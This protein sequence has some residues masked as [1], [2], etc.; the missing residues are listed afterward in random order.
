[1]ENLKFISKTKTVT[2]HFSKLLI[3][4]LLT[5]TFSFQSCTKKKKETVKESRDFVHHSI[6]QKVRLGDGIPLSIDVSVRWKVEDFASF[7]KQ[8]SN[9]NEFDSL[10]LTPRKLEL[11][12]II[13][14]QFD[15]VDTLFNSKRQTYIKAMKEYLKNN[16]GEP[17][18]AI[19][20]VIISD[21]IFPKSYLE[22]KERLA[23]QQQELQ[24]IRKQSIIN[25]ERAEANKRQAEADGKVT[26]TEAEVNAKVQRI[27]AETEKSIRATR[28]AKAETE[29]QVAQLRAESDAAKQ[30]LLAKARLEEKTDLKNLE[31][32]QKNELAKMQFE[33]DMR[34]AKLCTDNPVYATYMVN[35]ELASKVQIA[36]LPNN[37]DASVFNSL[38]GKSSVR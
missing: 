32:N 14:N 38:L 9:S 25:I 16:L 1:M 27:N 11:A 36:V 22:S 2:I 31:I 26:M 18:I 19:K 28:L 13:S 6:L 21:I 20:E 29:K 10:V 12:N 15:H 37:Q 4:M 34:M 24:T 3:A 23:M 8:F 33:N 7:K 35:K 17:G 30:K 5:F